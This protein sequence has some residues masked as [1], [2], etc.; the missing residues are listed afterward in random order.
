MTTNDR[1]NGTL[2]ENLITLL[3]HSNEHGKTISNLIESNLYEG[4]YR[5]VA[6]R[7]I[8]YWRKYDCAPGIHTGDLFPEIEDRAN[9]RGNTFRRI[10]RSMASLWEAGINSDYVLN[11]ATAYKRGV[12]I[13]STILESAE[14][15]NNLGEKAIDHIEDLWATVLRGAKDTSFNP[16]MRLTEYDR[17]LDNLAK[18]QSEFTTGIDQ[19]DQAGIVPYRGALMM[20]L[21]KA[22]GGKSWWLINLGKRAAFNDRKKVVH[23]SLEMSEE[24]NGQRYYQSVWSIPKRQSEFELS[25]LKIREDELVGIRREPVI[26]DFSFNSKGYSEEIALRVEQYV[27]GFQNI[28]IKRFP[29]RS[30][31]PNGIRAYLDNLEA[32]EGFIPDMLILDYASIMKTDTRNHRIDIGRNIEELRAIGVERNLAVVSAHQANRAGA[33]SRTIKST[34]A[35]EDWS[36]VQT[37]DTILTFSQTKAEKQL[38]LGRLYVAN[39]RDEEDEWGVIVGQGIPIG[40]FCLP[41]NSHRLTEDYWQFVEPPKEDD[42]EDAMDEDDE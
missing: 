8:D 19:L 17:I 20:L 39:A 23:I 4:E 10:V 31:T 27:A 1:L 6:E 28:I 24:L 36:M 12:V 16:G 15:I 22:K 9:R 38:G 5:T 11:Q 2:Q 14:Q 13:K 41:H 32:A 25:Y 7:C 29:P 37:A 21:A 33:D 35:G 34:H 18:R 3:A 42:D 26:P 30:L 40:Q